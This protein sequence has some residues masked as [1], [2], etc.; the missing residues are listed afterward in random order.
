MAVHRVTAM[1]VSMATILTIPM[2]ANG[3]QTAPGKL[4]WNQGFQ[5]DSDIGFDVNGI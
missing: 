1:L 3:L 2:V 5:R 4:Y